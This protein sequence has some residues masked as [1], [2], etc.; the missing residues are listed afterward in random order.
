VLKGGW[1]EEFYFLWKHIALHPIT[2]VELL[3]QR[4]RYSRIKNRRFSNKGLWPLPFST[5]CQIVH[6]QHILQLDLGMWP[7]TSLTYEGVHVT[8]TTHIL[9]QFGFKFS[10]GPI[11]VH[12]QLILQRD[13][14]WPL[15]SVC[16]LWAHYHMKVSMLRFATIGLQL[17]AI[18]LIEIEI[19]SSY[20]SHTHSKSGLRNV[21][22][23]QKKPKENHLSLNNTLVLSWIWC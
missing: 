4:F 1:S 21:Y 7:L 8:S 3:I 20:F 16:D 2:N 13:L 18:Y 6:V 22:F 5:N 19:V 11:I 9:F 15:T 12:V 23:M 14:R 10:N 17:L